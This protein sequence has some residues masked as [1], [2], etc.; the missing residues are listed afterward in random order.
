M[1]LRSPLKGEDRYFD[2]SKLKIVMVLVYKHNA[3]YLG[4]LRLLSD[5]DCWK[6][7]TDCTKV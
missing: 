2:F 4:N 3:I 6:E 7:K 5:K 1:V